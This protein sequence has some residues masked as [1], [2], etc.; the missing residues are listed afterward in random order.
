LSRCSSSCRDG[1]GNAK[2]GCPLPLPL[3]LPLPL[4][5]AYQLWAS[6]RCTWGATSQSSDHRL[7]ELLQRK[8]RRDGK[9][10]VKLIHAH[11][12]FLTEVST[13]GK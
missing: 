7:L 13:F 2:L 12:L 10:E 11:C 5:R 1:L 4:P 6:E 8:R 3:L 9:F